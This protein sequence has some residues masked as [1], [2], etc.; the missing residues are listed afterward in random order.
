MKHSTFIDQL[1]A[2]RFPKEWETW[3]SENMRHYGLL[4]DAERARL[5][6]IARVLVAEKSWEGCDGLQVSEMMKLTVAA[7]AALLLLGLEHDYFSRV[8]SIVLFPTAFELPAESWEER[9]S[10]A[11]GRAVDYG[12]VF[13][14]WETVLAEARDPTTG[15][16]LVIHEFTHQLD[17]LDGYTNGAP[18]LRSL[19][20][21]RR[22]RQVMQGTF[23]RLRRDL[24]K[25]R[26]TLLGSYAATNPT[27]FFSVASEKF[28]SLPGRLRQAHPDLFQVLAEYYR[29]DPLQ[30]FEA[31]AVADQ[32]P[33]AASTP[34]GTT[35]EQAPAA[36]AE[37]LPR[38]DFIDFNCPYCQRPVSFP[39][40]EAGTLKQCPN[41][42]ES[43]IIPEDAR[44][45]ERIPFPIKTERLLLR[46]FQTL[47]AKDLADLMSNPETLRYL[48]WTAMNLEDVEEW[49]AGQSGIRFPHPTD[50]CYFA[51]EETQA[52]KVIGFVMFWFVHDEFDLAQFEIIIHP[53]WQRKGYATEAVRGLL[54]YAFKGLRARRLMAEFDSR[55]LPA[56]RLLLKAGLRQESECIQ[57]RF[58]KG[59]WVN[60]VG[61]ALLRAE[62]EGQRSS[63]RPA[64]RHSE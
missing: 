24:Q 29:V 55:N 36:T 47:D 44:Q 6:D 57:D 35:S 39:K 62:Y 33:A 23:Q 26:S 52:A 51:V 27:E 8:L 9:G 5:Q 17:F 58:L 53:D 7:Q 13:L 32:P 43:M 14:S 64:A 38:P 28:F 49:I 3:L 50:Y 42:D 59:A 41:C 11:L 30:W 15:H 22:W 10:T 2:Q 31:K 20:Q 18:P 48:A 61:F 25:G 54:A 37:A 19:E 45:A 16:N 4:S 34:E 63:A 56:R 46:R 60:T 40:V 21:S 12:T 1:L